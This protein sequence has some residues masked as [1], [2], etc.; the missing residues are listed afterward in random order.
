PVTA[1][2][3]AGRYGLS[4]EHTAGALERLA[5]RG[6]VGQGSYLAD[7]AAPQ[8]VHIA[9]LDEIQ[10]RQVHARRVPRPVASA[11]Q[12]SAFLLR[13][14]HLHPD[15]RLV[16]PPGVL[17]AL[18]LLQGE[19]L[20]ARVWEQDLLPARLESYEREWL[21]RLGLAREGVG[22]AFDRARRDPAP[23]TPVG[24]GA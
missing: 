16:G 18:E 11:D 2:W 1:A 14:H 22:A 13:R 19:D 24:V 6:L 10:R 8:F 23:S 9:V 15:H 20:P 12:F 17:A 21:H 5:A 3:P 4:L 7:A